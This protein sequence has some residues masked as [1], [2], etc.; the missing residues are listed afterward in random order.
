MS[1]RGES[2]PGPTV[3]LILLK[4]TKVLGMLSEGVGAWGGLA[5]QGLRDLHPQEFGAHPRRKLCG[6]LRPP[7][8]R[9]YNTAFSQERI[10]VE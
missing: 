3:D 4:E 2:V 6:R 7:E 9:A 1:V 10:I 8:D 5:Y